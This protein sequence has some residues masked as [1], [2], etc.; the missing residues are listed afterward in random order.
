MVN[1]RILGVAEQHM[2]IHALA[3]C[4]DERDVRPIKCRQVVVL[5]VVRFA[6]DDPVLKVLA[7]RSRGFFSTPRDSSFFH[8]DGNGEDELEIIFIFPLILHE[9]P[10]IK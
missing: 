5:C 9:I 2:L 1:R 3:V 7:E 6:Q 4:V 8:Q 10:V